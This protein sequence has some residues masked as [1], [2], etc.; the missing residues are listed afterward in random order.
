MIGCPSRIVI[1]T[2]LNALPD[3]LLA[4]EAA[5]KS[6]VDTTVAA[7]SVGAYLATSTE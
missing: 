7:L 2:A 4:T 5:G 3:W 1:E 6:D